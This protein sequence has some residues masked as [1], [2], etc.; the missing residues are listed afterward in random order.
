MA[1]KTILRKATVKGVEDL[2]L[3]VAVV[4]VEVDCV[5]D[6]DNVEDM[7]GSEEVGSDLEGLVVGEMVGETAA[8]VV[9][10]VARA[11]TEERVVVVVA[12]EMAILADEMEV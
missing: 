3:A 4:E 6:T 1:H 8:Q 11:A 5:V 12:L 10:R 9:A 7:G 2:A